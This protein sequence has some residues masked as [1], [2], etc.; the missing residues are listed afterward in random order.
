MAVRR[1]VFPV[2]LARARVGAGGERLALVAVGIV[3]GAAAIAAVLGGRLV[4]QDRS[5][6]DATRQLPASDR[7]LTVGWFGAYGGTWR[8]LDRVV[9]A[10][11]KQTTGEAPARAML[12]REASVGGRFINLRGADGL[13][14]YVHL[15][16][17]RLPKACVPSR[18]EVLRLQGTGPI[19]S[20]K[21]M[22][23]VQVGTA[24]PRP[25]RA[26]C[27]LRRAGDL[28]D[29][30]CRRPVPPARSPRPSCS[31]RTST[32]SRR[33]RSSPRS[34]APTPGSSRCSPA[35]SIPGRSAPTAKQVEDVRAALEAR[36]GSYQVTA[37]TD[38][39]TA[40]VASSRV[41]ARRLLLL[42]GE[43]GAL[44]LA[45]TVL[46]AS[47]LRREAGA[48]RRRLALGRGAPVAG[49]ARHVRRDCD[50]RARRDDR[51]LV[52]RRRR[53]GRSPRT[54]PARPPGRSSTMRSPPVAGSSRRPQPSPC[55][56]SCS[57]SRSA[58]RAFASAAS[59]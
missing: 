14:S 22:R 54:R 59:Q 6:A 47:A 43:T 10:E 9:T 28:R 56:A 35:T 20:T 32:G 50:R 44:L 29:R 53:R 52:H 31:R 42:G 45:F 48:A 33:R 39:L 8:S 25:G 24:T 12:Y 26:V 27:I 15:L 16:S 30:H 37:P 36:S 38:E 13:A 18:C 2:R 41:A 55:P 19:P 17:G 5:L 23:L 58:R 46:A 3:A 40:A 11:L 4:M 21:G 51:R 57:T 49:R 34:S 1:F 7:S